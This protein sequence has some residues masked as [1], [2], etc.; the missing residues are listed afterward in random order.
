PYVSDLCIMA[1]AEGMLYQVL[2][3]EILYLAAERYQLPFIPQVS[4][5]FENRAI[6]RDWTLNHKE[7]VFYDE[8]IHQ[9]YKK[10]IGGIS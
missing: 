2:I 1:A 5:S 4:A 3:T 7:D 9:Q 8:S 10:S 6:S